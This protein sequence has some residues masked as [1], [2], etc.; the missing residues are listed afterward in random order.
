[1]FLLPIISYPNSTVD[2]E[3]VGLWHCAGNWLEIV[4]KSLKSHDNSER[5]W[6]GLYE[7][8][9]Q[10]KSKTI[11]RKEGNYCTLCDMCELMQGILT[12]AF[13]W[14]V[15]VHSLIT[16]T[17]L[18]YLSFDALVVLGFIHW[19]WKERKQQ[20]TAAVKQRSFKVGKR[21]YQTVI[22]LDFVHNNWRWILTFAN[23]SS[24]YWS[25]VVFSPLI[26]G[27]FKTITSSNKYLTRYIIKAT[28][29]IVG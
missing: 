23:V 22:S 1:M 6:T 25:P 16:N 26:A 18:V 28:P 4:E 19:R 21:Y 12:L 14:T 15:E 27:S 24:S 8:P 7:V 11:N 2:F 5:V 20:S 9:T 10:Q 3:Y 17:S 29:T 13:I